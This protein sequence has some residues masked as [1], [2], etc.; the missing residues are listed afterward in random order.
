VSSNHP[1]V[2]FV[3]PCYKLAH[4][5]RE[6]V[7]SI[8]GQTYPHLEVL[9][10]DDCSPDGTPAVAATYADARV[11]Y[12]RNEPNL[13]HLRN[14]QKGIDLSRGQLLWL[15][16]ADDRLRRPYAAER[17]VR[18]FEDEPGASFVFCPSVR[19]E[20]ERELDV[21]GAHG[22]HDRVFRR[23]EFLRTL[24]RGN[25]V[26]APAVCARKSYYGRIGGFPLD[27]PF[28]GDWY[29]W[30]RFALEGDVVYLSEPMAAYRFHA[31]NMTKTFTTERTQALVRDEIAVG[32]RLLRDAEAHGDED[33]SRLALRAVAEDYSARV[34][35]R[36]ADGWPRGLTW[37][38]FERSLQ[39]HGA[40]PGEIRFIVSRAAAAAG[41]GHW[42]AGHTRPARTAYFR[43]LQNRPKL[44]TCAKLLLAASGTTGRRLR[45]GI[46]SWR[47]HRGTEAR[48][49]GTG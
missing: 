13:G 39:E 20:G 32:W 6:C 2:S 1:L 28:A 41:D 23:P 46:T 14:Y 49:S 10:M 44:R 12:V 40:S 45:D 31:L 37:D 48:S 25:S 38:E 36:I 35:R 47:D 18:A 24:L 4:F 7:D 9:I 22:P 26:S 27:L 17:V 8:L 43:S 21:Y 5:L 11:R 29:V 42:E 33:S 15:I 16:S 34:Y 3:V 30:A 19:F